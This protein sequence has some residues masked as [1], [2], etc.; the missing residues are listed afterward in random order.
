[1]IPNILYLENLHYMFSDQFYGST[2]TGMQLKVFYMKHM[3]YQG[4]IQQVGVC[5]Q[6]FC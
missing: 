5:G 2:A 3:E 6:M 1:M 4:Y